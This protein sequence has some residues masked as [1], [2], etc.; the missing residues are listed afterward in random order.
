MRVNLMERLLISH[1]KVSTLHRIFQPR[2][3]GFSLFANL[4][5]RADITARLTPSTTLLWGQGVLGSDV[6][7]TMSQYLDTARGQ[8]VIW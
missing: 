4:N 3:Q 2:S 7:W 5:M 6:L 8:S 1:D